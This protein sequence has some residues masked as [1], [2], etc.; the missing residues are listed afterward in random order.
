[1][2]FGIKFF[3]QLNDYKWI[4]FTIN[5]TKDKIKGYCDYYLYENRNNC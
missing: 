3:N 1:M 5:V 4:Y 2:G